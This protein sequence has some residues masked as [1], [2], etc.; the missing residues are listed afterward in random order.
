MPRFPSEEECRTDC[1]CSALDR[2]VVDGEVELVTERISLECNCQGADCP[3]NLEEATQQ[4]CGELAE[5]ATLATGCGMAAIE[6]FTGYGFAQLVFDAT[7]G[8]LIGMSSSGDT[9]SEPCMTM[10]TVAGQA[11]ECD[12]VTR[13]RPCDAPTTSAVPRCE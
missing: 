11:F 4:I 10:S 6:I 5:Y 2:V 8:S 9:P 1:H 3:A 13:C 7:S 12:E